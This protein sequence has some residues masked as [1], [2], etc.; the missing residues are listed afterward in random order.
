MNFIPEKRI[1]TTESLQKFKESAASKAI[2]LWVAMLQNSVVEKGFRTTSHNPNFRNFDEYFEKVRSVLLATPPVK[3]EMRFGNIAFR[4][5]HD[6]IQSINQKFC[7]ELM[8]INS[9][10]TSFALELSEYLNDAYG[11]ETRIDYGTGHE[12]NFILFLMLLNKLKPFPEESYVQVVHQIFYNYI[13]T[14]RKIQLQ[15]NL[16]PAGSHGVWGLDDYHFLPFVFGAAE[17]INNQEIPTPAAAMHQAV[18][19]NLSDAYMY[20]N[21]LKFIIDIKKGV[22]LSVSSPILHS[23][24]AAANWSKVAKGMLPMYADEVLGKLPVVQHIK[25]GRIFPFE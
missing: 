4:D 7:L 12:L 5:F 16:E 13:F 8:S 21:C 3:G 14:M 2:Q 10:E 25:F 22:P 20:I 6:K 15:Y 9:L 18:I 23:I 19:S 17:L 11:S 1:K 24:S